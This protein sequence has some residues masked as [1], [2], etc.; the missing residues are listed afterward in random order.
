M[1]PTTKIDK[2]L[3]LSNLGTV[4][5]W[6]T[7]LLSP[8]C[9]PIFAAL[10]SVFGLGGFELFG[11]WTMY[12]F[13]GLVLVTVA[14]SILSYLQ[15]RQLIPVVVS[16]LSTVVVFYAYYVNFSQSIVYIGMIGLLVGTVL[17]YWLTKTMKPTLELQSEITCPACGHRAVEA[18]P[19]D[20][21]QYFYE[22][23]NCQTVLKPIAGDCC[24]FCSYGT[25]KCP[26]I[27]Q[28]MSCC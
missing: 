3:T 13:Q 11:G 12:V 14:G 7:A 27:Q 6:L 17:N 22:C 4:G 21:C 19:T 20:A 26:P 15:H 2:I 25:V 9:F 8:C 10:A 18:M 24:V 1:S 23:T 5:L 28:G 16:I